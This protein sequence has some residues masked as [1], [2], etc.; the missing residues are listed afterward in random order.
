MGFVMFYILLTNALH[1]SSTCVRETI[2]V[3]LTYGEASD[4][5]GFAV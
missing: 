3:I 2:L 5:L 1:L 4:F